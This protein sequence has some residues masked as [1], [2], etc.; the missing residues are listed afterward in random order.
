MWARL[1]PLLVILS[2]ALNV[3][4]VAMWGMRAV[5]ARVGPRAGPMSCPL[6]RQLG[7]TE[8]QWQEIEPRLAEFQKSARKL[9]RSIHGR[10]LEMID[11]VAASE[12]DREAIRRKQEEIRAGQHKMQELVIEHLLAEKAVLTPEQ[13]NALFR[14]F[15]QRTGCAGRGPMAGI[16]PRKGPLDQ[17]PPDA[18][19]RCE[20]TR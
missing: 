3:A 9:R 4:F 19:S 8:Q 6:H 1:K 11:L 13:G 16:V 7:I 14:L 20:E 10:R 17:R 15:R 5:R 12:P 2:L 18:E